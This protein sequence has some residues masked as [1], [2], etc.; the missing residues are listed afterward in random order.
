MIS[1]VLSHDERDELVNG[2]RANVGLI[3][4][5]IW[6]PLDQDDSYRKL[7]RTLWIRSCKIAA[8]YAETSAGAR[9][10]KKRVRDVIP[11]SRLAS[12]GDFEYE[13]DA[14]VQLLPPSPSPQ[15]AAPTRGPDGYFNGVGRREESEPSSNEVETPK[16]SWML[17][18]VEEYIAWVTASSKCS[19]PEHEALVTLI[20]IFG[21]FLCPRVA[22]IL[23]ALLL[24]DSG[25]IV[26][27]RRIR[28]F[29][30]IVRLLDYNST[31]TR[32]ILDLYSI[33]TPFILINLY[34]AVLLIRLGVSSSDKALDPGCEP[35]PRFSVTNVS[36]AQLEGRIFS[37]SV[38]SL[39]R[40]GP[41]DSQ[42]RQNR[43]LRQCE[44]RRELGLLKPQ[45]QA[46]K[47]PGDVHQVHC[48]FQ[49][50]RLRM[51]YIDN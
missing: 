46:P 36:E 23:L 27:C 31:T 40:S 9:P 47:R 7:N 5:T 37:E 34:S 13:D 6:T 48:S 24:L 18:E 38:R 51:P 33:Y 25:G 41:R 39:W 19:R 15:A 14:E 22:E 26:P 1:S 50:E 10:K 44:L 4:D 11:E 20:A 35:P 42:T 29:P 49:N 28:L 8:N 30:A 21:K 16:E 3:A 12:Y 17:D 43:G 45:T 2:A 32:F